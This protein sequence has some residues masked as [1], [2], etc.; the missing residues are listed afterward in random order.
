MED[1]LDTTFRVLA[2]TPN[3]AA[4]HL[5][6]PAMDS[7]FQ[8]IRHRA[9]RAI[10]ARPNAA[11]HRN[12]VARLHTIDPQGRYLIEENPR[13]LTRV[14]REAIL[15]SDP[16]MCANG[17]R[18]AV[19]FCQYD[20]V[21]TLLNAL[22]GSPEPQATILGQALKALAESLYRE[23]AAQRQHAK[24]RQ[25]QLV[26]RQVVGALELSVNRFGRHKRR[27][28]VEAL[29]LLAPHDNPTLRQILQDPHHPAFLTL[30][31]ILSKSERGP[32]V[33]LLLSFLEDPK[34]PSAA[35][36]VLAKRT[37][38]RLVEALL[39]K[40]GREPPAV[41]AQNLKRLEAVA[42]AR[43]DQALLDRL[44]ELE[45]HAAVRLVMLSATP[46]P[47]AFAVVEH[48]LLHGKPEGKR[49]AAEALQQ[50]HGAEANALALEAL[51][52]DDPEVQAR[53]LVQLRQRGIPG[54]LGRLVEALDSPHAVV[55]KAARRSLAEFT[56]PRFLSTFDLLD[57]EVR[58][59][60]GE[61]VKKIDPHTVPL[62]RAEMTSKVRTRRLRALA[63]SRSLGLV[64]EVEESILPLL[65]DED[66]FV[67]A[68]AAATLGQSRSLASQ[69][70]LFT[71]LGDRSPAVR[72]AARKG[73]DD[74]LRGGGRPPASPAPKPQEP[75][76]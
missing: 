37:D 33:R 4:V 40:I 10:L 8:A 49:A 6:I 52:D 58:Q 31:E 42:W 51:A 15:G 64:P 63:V 59:S 20:L 23:L 75:R 55:R 3:D 11:G 39:R 45:Q 66:H 62:L 2:E 43:R 9:L 24:H 34:A 46:R 17:C 18:A 67:R 35:L 47:Q 72:E 14:V 7:R 41:V 50:F 44:D 13:R 12:V 74:R 60:T 76:P 38:P 53:I 1:G 27:E 57:E 61:L 28:V 16:Q 65:Q 19:W 30:V 69:A 32:V 36:S 70:A 71:A 22:E 73:L 54:A 48:L 29:V 21:P 56:F 5:L 68:E 25:Q 26:R